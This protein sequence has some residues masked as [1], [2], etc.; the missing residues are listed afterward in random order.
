MLASCHEHPFDV[1]N[2]H[3]PYTT[4]VALT[5]NVIMINDNNTKGGD[6]MKTMTA[7]E[8]AA[9]LNVSPKS[10]RAYLRRAHTRNA[11]AKNTTWAID[12]KTCAAA[13]KHFAAKR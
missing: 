1:I 9:S 12:A 6:D 2:L 8:L 4:R 13:R 7:T 3:N 11:D 10:L 5:Y